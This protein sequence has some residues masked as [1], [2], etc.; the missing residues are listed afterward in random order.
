MP[1]NLGLNGKMIIYAFFK[2]TVKANIKIIVCSLGEDLFL[3]NV[4]GIIYLSV[5]DFLFIHR[6]TI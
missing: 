2:R 3:I 1:T 6:L 4:Y 5:H